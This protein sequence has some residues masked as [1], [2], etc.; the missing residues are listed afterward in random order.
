MVTA[1]ALMSLITESTTSW[2][3]ASSLPTRSSCAVCAALTSAR[4]TAEPAALNSSRILVVVA[5]T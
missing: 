4:A 2:S 1:V 5:F 3:D